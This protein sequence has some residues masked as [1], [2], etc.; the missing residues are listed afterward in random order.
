[1]NIITAP[2]TKK[3]FDVDSE[4]AKL[5]DRYGRNRFGQSCLLARG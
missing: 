4:N 3:A 5:R 1:M 2:E